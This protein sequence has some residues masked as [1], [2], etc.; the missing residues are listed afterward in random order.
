[1]EEIIDFINNLKLSDNTKKNY[2]SNF[3]TI[4]KVLSVNGS[5]DYLDDVDVLL[6]YLITL[7][8]VSSKRTKASVISRILQSDKNRYSIQIKELRGYIMVLNKNETVN[9]FKPE[10]PL[11][12]IKK[13]VN[14]I[15]DD[16]KAKL[17][18]MLVT[19]HPVLRGDYNT[20]KLKNI[21]ENT[22]NYYDGIRL[23]F[24]KLLKV[25]NDIRPIK[26]NTKEKKLINQI[27]KDGDEYL[28]GFNTEHGFNKYLRRISNKY[29]GYNYG[30]QHY[31]KLYTST[32]L[33]G[34][35]KLD[36][37]A[38]DLANQMNHSSSTQKKSYLHEI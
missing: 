34:K 36:K 7:P 21:N 35:I 27:K 5:L 18:L 16:D 14:G 28:F 11:K 9:S 29:I 37:K 1:M 4:H 25:D 22:D 17:L 6:H 24:N 15:E 10:L 30:I 2:I 26:L 19:N 38:E 13:K 31:R 33:K 20:I 8:S 3:K 12:E 23:V 32:E